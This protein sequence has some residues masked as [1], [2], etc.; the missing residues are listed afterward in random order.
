MSLTIDLDPGLEARL[1]DEAAKQ[2]V[3]A[4][5]YVAAALEG[6]FQH[7]QSES[8]SLSA[9]EADLL[10]EINLGISPAAWQRYHDLMKMR[11]AETLSSEEHQALID[12]S[13][14]IEQANARRIERVV[15]LATLRQVPV[16]QLM[17]QLGIGPLSDD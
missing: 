16:N 11:N 15:E 12:L 1:R 7:P 6:L 13:N 10:Q 4:A 8:T 3:D 2:G 17:R 9:A 5:T 14:E